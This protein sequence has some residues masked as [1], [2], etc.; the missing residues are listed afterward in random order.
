VLGF[1]ATAPEIFLFVSLFPYVVRA[2]AVAQGGLW[3]QLDL[4][5]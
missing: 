4:K 2:A 1:S 3:G 5:L